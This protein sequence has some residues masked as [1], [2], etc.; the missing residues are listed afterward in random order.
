[1]FALLGAFLLAAVAAQW[2]PVQD[3]GHWYQ[4]YSDLAVVATFENASTC[5]TADYGLNSNG[6]I[7]V[8]N[9]ERQYSVNGSEHGTSAEHGQLRGTLLDL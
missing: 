3:L 7:S 1:M 4:T 6:T 2:A 9:R 8:W 5:V